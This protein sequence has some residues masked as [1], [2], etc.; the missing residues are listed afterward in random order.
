M[1]HKAPDQHKEVIKLLRAKP[2]KRTPDQLSNC[3]KFMEEF[4]RE[5]VLTRRTGFILLTHRQFIA[6][7]RYVEGYSKS[8]AK[9]ELQTALAD[10]SV[11][12]LMENGVLV[13]AWRKATELDKERKDISKQ[14]FKG[15]S[16]KIS[17]NTARSMLSGEG[18]EMH[19][20]F[21]EPDPL[22]KGLLK[23]K[24]DVRVADPKVYLRPAHA[25]DS[26]AD[27]DDGDGTDDSDSS[28]GN[29]GTARSSSMRASPPTD[30]KRQ[31][32]GDVPII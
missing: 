32:S 30:R 8:E 18:P 16:V 12:Q 17:D 23:E 1:K 3:M 13:I 7:M 4:S 19:P 10:K 9:E 21:Y 2:G 14:V 20:Q 29:P 11:K 26:S 24:S 25:V 31:R 27:G 28:D 5:I 22:M 6:R 15:D